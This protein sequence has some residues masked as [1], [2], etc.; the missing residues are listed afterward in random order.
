MNIDRFAVIRELFDQVVD[1][2]DSE[3]EAALATAT[4][5]PA[6]AAEVLA[7]CRITYGNST[8]QFA[9]PLSAMLASAAAYVL[10]PGDT[11]GAWRVV[12]EIGSGGMGSV[13]LV[14]RTDGHYKQTAA[15]KFVK[16]IPRAETLSYFTRERQLL[17]SLSHPNVARLLDGGASPQGQPYL[18]MEYIG[19]VPID[20]Y[21]RE[22]KLDVPSI[23][24]LFAAAAS[25]VAFSHRQ[26]VVHCDLKP[27]NLFVDRDG[28]PVLLDFG[29]AKLLDQVGQ[30][31][32]DSGP[33]E[34]GDLVA[35]SQRKAGATTVARATPFTPRYAS[36]EQRERGMVSTASDI[37]SLG[38]VLRE[39][40]GRDASP[41]PSD[42]PLRDLELGAILDKAT[43]KDPAL[44]YAS[45]DALTDDIHRYLQHQPLLAMP[46]RALYPARKWFT[47]RWPV[48]V[49]AGVFAATVVGFTLKVVGES[50][51][52]RIAEQQAL[53]DRDRAQGAEQRAL[54]ERDATQLART[55]ALRERD[56]A[57]T[58][59]SEAERERDRAAAAERARA[60]ERDRAVAAESRAVAERNRATQAESS[61]KQTNEFLLSI[62][63]SGEPD[64][65][66]S[67]LP[68]SQVLTRAEARV[69]GKLSGQ[70]G[71]QAELFNMLG[72]VRNSMGSNDQARQ[73]FRRAIE[74]ERTQS[75]PLE[76]AKLL[77]DYAALDLATF[78]G[79]EALVT[80]REAMALVEKHAAPES[81]EM[82][83]T[84]R[85]LA[86]VLSSVGQVKEALAL[87]ESSL[88]I[89]E[90]L[91]PS[92]G[93]TSK[94]LSLLGAI[95]TMER[96]YK[97]AI[98]FHRRSAAIQ[99]KLDGEG[100]PSVL[101]QEVLIGVALGNDGRPAE[102]EVITRRVLAAFEKLYGRDNPATMRQYIRLSLLLGE[103]LR[104]REAIPPLMIAKSIAEKTSGRESNA[105]VIVQNNL[106]RLLLDLGLMDE[107]VAVV[108]EQIPIARKLWSP[109][110]TGLL[111]MER[112]AG[113][114]LTITGH[115]AEARP[116]LI[117]VYEKCRRLLGDSH[118]DTVRA[119]L[120]LAMV[121]TSA[122]KLDEA[123]AWLAKAD[124]KLPNE[125]LLVIQRSRA[126]GTLA[127]RRGNYAAA[128]KDFEK[129][130]EECAKAYKENNAARWLPR[131][132]RIELL[133]A[134]NQGNDRAEA[135]DLAAQ[136]LEKLTPLL[137]PK[138]NDIAKLKQLA[139]P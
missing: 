5:D 84:K 123:A 83:E 3:R 46:Q 30:A 131:L 95:A 44:R 4:S 119:L 24:Q 78:G 127:M 107:M 93:Q 65:K 106:A 134:R 58:A 36:P 74:L 104:K 39:L 41:I 110:S 90:K 66:S 109:D 22:H 70:T 29:I 139:Q 50:N 25:A 111:L 91:D 67:D 81:A 115:A 118:R 19:G 37:Y 11:L 15:L 97:D 47:R 117:A 59:R 69:E 9:Q 49:A 68:M 98:E 40:L 8:T 61:T 77:R 43:N 56:A 130:E 126:S 87:G 28:R 51:R 63:E 53:A 86:S 38:V 52:A 55:E 113:H 82:A 80:M 122:G 114:A 13:Y 99:L 21:C 121:E 112:N 100:S 62:F 124:E 17:A 103:Q 72:R 75:R 34:T 132:D 14:E 45:V 92:G 96:R 7:L 32:M 105:Y 116:I 88:A 48:A 16:G 18:V 71:M 125:R 85:A 102:A 26:L 76:L 6:I 10:S 101:G 1:L 2:P 138:A 42:A 120:D 27:S 133:N 129:S 137:D 79:K 60:Q 31:Q 136:T 64:A 23:L 94:S 57:Q 20:K 33:V 54:S 35:D 135:R 108:R 89:N 12:R 128:L 73:N